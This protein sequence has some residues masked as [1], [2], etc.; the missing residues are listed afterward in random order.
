[1]AADIRRTDSLTGDERVHGYRN[2]LLE[3]GQILSV[4]D[5][6]TDDFKGQLVPSETVYETEK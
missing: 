2:L 5:Y 3:K 4:A 1:M 6:S